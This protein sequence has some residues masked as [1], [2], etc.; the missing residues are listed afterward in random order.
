[1]DLCVPWGALVLIDE[2]E[3]LLEVAISHQFPTD[4]PS[5][6]LDLPRSPLELAAAHQDRARAQRD[7]LRDAPPPRVRCS[8][9]PAPPAPSPSLCR[10]PPCAHVPTT[11]W[12]V[13]LPLHD[14]VWIQVLPGRPLPHL[15]PRPRARPRLP[16]PPPCHP[17]SAPPTVIVRCLPPLPPCSRACSA[18]CATTRSTP[19]RA[20][21]SG[22]T[23]HLHESP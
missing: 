1:M 3:M 23:H 12:P 10:P 16:G 20:R 11:T 19:P 9:L 2:A 5:T 14:R 8:P 18:R 15:Q 4:L 21:R 13:A 7:G 22:A 17:L 6:S